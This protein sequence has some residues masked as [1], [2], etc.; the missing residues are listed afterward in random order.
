MLKASWGGGG[1]GMRIVESEDQ[2]LDSVRMGRSEAAAAF[3]N[4][5]VYLEKLIR[6]A[7]HVEVQLLGDKHG[8]IVHL[9]ERDC[10]IQRRNQKIIERAPALFLSDDQRENLCQS[11]LRLAG[12]VSYVS[13]GNSGIFI[14]R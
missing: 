9:F 8:N 4:P 13:A 12:A 3:G 6:N 1:R 5:E 7:R 14:R 10:S 2:L 11:A